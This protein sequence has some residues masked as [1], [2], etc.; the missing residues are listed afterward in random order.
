MTSLQIVAT[1]VCV[2]PVMLL[3]VIWF[4]ALREAAHGIKGGQS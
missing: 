4:F 3:L 2:C 1:V